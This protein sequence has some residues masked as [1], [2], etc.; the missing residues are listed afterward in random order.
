VT[1]SAPTYATDSNTIALS[2]TAS[3][4]IRVVEV[5]WVN[6]RGGSGPAI[7]APGQST[8]WSEPEVRLMPGVNVITVTAFNP[9]GN[10]SSA[11]LT[12]DRA[13]NP[14]SI[15]NPGNRTSAEGEVMSLQLAG[16]D[17]DGDR[18]TYTSSA[19]PPRFPV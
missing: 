10:S 12:V 17:P 6:D 9:S 5:K 8:S 15:V 16:S 11:V 18:L 7:V 1:T 2:G 13:N 14:P 4:G 3:D 19:L